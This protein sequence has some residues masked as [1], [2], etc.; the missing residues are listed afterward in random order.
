[1][2]GWVGPGWSRF[3]TL[4]NEWMGSPKCRFG[5]DCPYFSFSILVILRFTN[6]PFPL[7]FENFNGG[8]AVFIF[9]RFN[10]KIF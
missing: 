9:G 2:D 7:P 5:R 10:K 3:Y 8:A 1:M 6:P 4:E